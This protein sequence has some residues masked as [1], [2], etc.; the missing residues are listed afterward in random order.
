LIWVFSL[1]LW[2]WLRLIKEPNFGLI[3]CIVK[4]LGF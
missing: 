1:L 3:N 4:F 2:D